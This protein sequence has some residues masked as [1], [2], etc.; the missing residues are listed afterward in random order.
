ME[1]WLPYLVLNAAGLAV[2]I[3]AWSIVRLGGR[4]RP[5]LAGMI[6]ALIIAKAVLTWV[7]VWEA[8]CFPFSWYIYLQSYALPLLALAFF[9]AAVPQLT[10]PWNRHVVVTFVLA[11]YIHLGLCGTWWMVDRPAVGEEQFPDAAHHLR[12][13]TP[14][15]CAPC[16][17]AI[18]V[19][20]VGLMVSERE[21]A[22]R[23]LT[24]PEQGTTR[25]NTYRGLILS[26]GGTPWRARMAHAEIAELCRE[27]QVTVIDFPDLRHAITTLGTGDAVTLHD[28][29]L[30]QPVPLTRDELGERYGGVAIMIERQ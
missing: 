1:G 27:G 2:F 26:L 28:P 18:A 8:R 23:C 30:L 4:W 16:A 15:T 10:V 21:M 3:G 20:Y 22:D 12:Q 17:A 19:S 14:Y 9:G 24:V 7:P 13:S 11:L 29:L 5:V 25:F 6:L